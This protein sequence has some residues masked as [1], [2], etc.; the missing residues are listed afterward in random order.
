MSEKF[1]KAISV[2]AGDQGET[3]DI[4]RKKRI[5]TKKEKKLRVTVV[6]LSVLLA[7]FLFMSGLYT[8]IVY[9]NNAFVS[10][11]RTIWIETAMTTK[12]HLWLA[13]WFFPKEV[14]DSVMGHQNPTEGVVGGLDNLHVLDGSAGYEDMPMGDDTPQ[15]VEDILGQKELSVGDKDYAGNTV[16][17]NDIEEGLV[18]SEIVGPSYRGQIMLIDDPSRVYIGMTQ[19]PGITGMRILEMMEHYDAVAAVNASGF[20]DPNE[21]GNGGEV[22]GMSLSEGQYWGEYAWYYG[23]I[24]LTNE[25]KLV[26]G[27][28]RNWDTY[29]NIRDGMQFSPVLIADG[30][31]QVSGSSGYGIQPRTAVGQR[32]DG[33]IVFLVIDGRDITHSIGCTVDDMAEELLKYDV[34]NASSCDGGATTALAYK[35]KVLNKN[36]SLHPDLGRILPNAFMVRSKADAED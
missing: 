15:K 7:F 9:S 28:I 33:V 35:G 31:K 27:N 14:I 8:F 36:C 3:V 20:Q 6:L 26:V 5:K 1:A 12:S 22:V 34:V 25:N 30:E 21:N 19:Y 29:G 32:E 13:E 2:R 16:L 10:Y 11:W 4:V 24:V 18:V 17:I 23:S